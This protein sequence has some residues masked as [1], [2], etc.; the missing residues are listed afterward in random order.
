MTFHA[1]SMGWCHSFDVNHSVIR[2]RCVWIRFYARHVYEHHSC[3]LSMGETI[4]NIHPFIK[5]Y[6]FKTQFSAAD[7]FFIFIHR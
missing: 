4:A 1:T 7:A 6:L 2:W 5:H 3:H